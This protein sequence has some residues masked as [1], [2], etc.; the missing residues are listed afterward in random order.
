MAS[1]DSHG[2]NFDNLD[3][4]NFIYGNNGCGKSTLTKVLSSPEQFEDS[5][6]AFSNS[7]YKMLV[8]NKEF[9]TN[10]FNQNN[11]IPGIFTLGKDA[12]E[13]QRKIKELQDKRNLQQIKQIPLESAVAQE[14]AKQ[15]K[16]ESDF[17]E[18]AWAIKIK[19]DHEFSQVLR[20]VRNSKRN[21][22]DALVQKMPMISEP[23]DDITSLVKEIEKLFNANPQKVEE[24]NP[25]DIHN[26]C[27]IEYNVF[28]EKVIGKEDVNIS[29]LI[30]KLNI[31]DWVLV[32]KG[33]LENTEEQC[34]FCQ[35][36]VPIN[37]KEQLENYFDK[38]YFM[39]IT[40]IN[41]TGVLLKTVW[42]ELIE[43]L[44][45]VI[46]TYKEIVGTDK[47]LAIKNTAI[48]LNNQN[49]EI[50][51]KK[52]KEPSGV[53]N[54]PDLTEFITEYNESIKEINTEIVAYNTKIENIRREKEL[55]ATRVWNFIVHEIKSEY[56]K[57]NRE[58]QLV[59]R[60]KDGKSNSLKKVKTIIQNLDKEIEELQISA[61]GIDET[62]IK[63]NRQLTNFGFTNFKLEA[64]AEKGIYKI[65]RPN[66]EVA[67]ETLSE[68]EKTFI[69]F[70]YYYN[71]VLG[72]NM[73]ADSEKEKILV[74]DDPISSLDSKILFI[75]S[76]LIR[77]L[78]A[79]VG[80][81]SL[82]IKQIFVLTHNTYFYKEVTNRIEHNCSFYILSKHDNTT[83]VLSYTNNPIKNSYQLLW[84]E[85]SLSIDSPASITQ[86]IMRRI[87]E[88]YFSFTGNIELNT[89][90]RYFK[91]E[92][93]D[94]CKSLIAWVHDGS[95]SIFEDLFV[96]NVVETK[97]IYFKVFKRIFECSG[98]L[99]HFD[100][101]VKGSFDQ[102]KLHV[103]EEQGVIEVL[104]YVN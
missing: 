103:F 69:T 73:G 24:I 26:I 60:I 46:N 65:V 53:F 44:E 102:D 57:Y 83:S 82:S 13:I 45:K 38:T 62:V 64:T 61:I 16:L 96:S 14:L 33:Y 100:M 43:F 70:L 37:F 66:G 19:Y 18:R 81:D 6:V 52:L 27:N 93:I 39:K 15:E 23:V 58:W 78:I 90:V 87:L 11:E 72:S 28:S 55:L 88:N 12:I 94:I 97:Q 104:E 9:I 75:V 29:D 36:K 101:M 35:Q 5:Y 4:L 98:H 1:Y 74:I 71:L 48:K 95:H 86:N 40:K 79:E 68:G 91:N 3:L 77:N 59:S 31:D 51:E 99:G 25:Y 10:N 22:K 34:P 76:T 56:D 42:N 32:G 21:F 80:K 54:L 20:G 84:D 50:V 67:H 30:Q 49:L 92:E 7:D 41:E 2:V 89:L 85:L 47:I 17:I 63:I 8:Y